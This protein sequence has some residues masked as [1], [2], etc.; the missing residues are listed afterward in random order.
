MSKVETVPSLVVV[1]HSGGT[2]SGGKQTEAKHHPRSGMTLLMKAKTAK[3]GMPERESQW[4]C[5]VVH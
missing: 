5:D 2:V 3:V 1:G 4:V